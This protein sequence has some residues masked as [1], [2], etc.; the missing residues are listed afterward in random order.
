MLIYKQRFVLR[1]GGGGAELRIALVFLWPDNGFCLIIKS[2]LDKD[3]FLLASDEAQDKLI[4]LHSKSE[5]LEI[6]IV[7]NNT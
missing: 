1:G 3:L 5:Y 2:A 4:K 7:K 6:G